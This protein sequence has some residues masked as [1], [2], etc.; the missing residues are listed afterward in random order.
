MTLQDELLNVLQV[1]DGN[2]LWWEGS[3]PLESP[4]SGPLSKVP[5][6]ALAKLQCTVER[7]LSLLS[8]AII[9]WDMDL[10]VAALSDVSL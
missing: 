10:L 9:K 7:H 3:S 5:L 8:E 2:S 6:E 4:L 1:V